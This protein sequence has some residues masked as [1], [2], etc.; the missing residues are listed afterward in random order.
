M[1]ILNEIIEG[2][3][4]DEVSTSTLLRKCLVLGHKLNNP[5]LEQWVEWELQGYPSDVELPDYRRIGVVIKVNM[6]DGFRVAENFSIPPEWMDANFENFSN[7][8]L[9]ESISQVETFYSNDKTNV[10]FKIGNLVGYLSSQE[11]IKMDI[12]SAWGEASTAVVKNITD[13]VRVRILKFVLEIA[14]QFPQALEDESKIPNN[15]D[16]IQQIVNN[17][18]YGSATVLGIN[19]NSNIELNFQANDFSG[20]AKVLN[21][22]GLLEE[23]INELKT[24]FEEEPVLDGKKYG[25]KVAAWIGKMVQKAANGSLSIATSALS[26]ILEEIIKKYYG[27]T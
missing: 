20:V 4:G 25:P 14:K 16:R 21:K 6:T 18:I 23:D 9:R 10:N 22:Y 24:A 12:I 1:N 5:V 8:D 3:S 19:N 11:A 27:I 7:L 26:K 13:L 15:S 2:A 17:H